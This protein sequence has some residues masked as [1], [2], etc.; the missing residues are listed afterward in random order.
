M[1]STKL[2]H[3]KKI[4][5]IALCLALTVAYVPAVSIPASA[6]DELSATIY[7]GE[8]VSLKDT[9][10][11]DYYEIGTAKELFAF[12]AIANSGNYS[13][14]AILTDDIDLNPG[15]IFNADGT[16]TFNGEAVTEG[17]V[18]WTSIGDKKNP[19][20]GTFDGAGKTISGLYFKGTQ[21]YMGL[22]GN[23]SGLIKNLNITNTYFNT[24]ITSNEYQYLGGVSGSATG[25][26]NNC[27][28]SGAILG[29]SG[30][31]FYAGG[32]VGYSKGQVYNCKNTGVVDISI[33]GSYSYA[34][35]IVGALYGY[36]TAIISGCENTGNISVYADESNGYAGGIVGFT[37]FDSNVEKCIN[38]GDVDGEADKYAYVGGVAGHIYGNLHTSYSFGNMSAK[39]GT[40][41]DYYK[42]A[43]AVVVGKANY[44]VVDNC[45]GVGTAVTLGGS[46]QYAAG[47]CA[48]Q[49]EAAS[50]LNNYY[51]SENIAIGVDFVAEPAEGEFYESQAEGKTP[52]QFASGEVA[53]LLGEPF[54]QNVDNGEEVQMYPVFDGAKVYYAE[55]FGYSNYPVP[56]Y[57]ADNFFEITNADELVWFSNYVNKINPSA[58]AIL[59]ADIDYENNEWKTILSTGLYY[60]TTEYSDLGYLGT[61]D[62]NG[63]IIKNF[64]LK[65]TSG[66]NCTVGLFGTLSGTV[67]N[68]GVEGV[69]FDLNGATD[70]RA[71]G[72]A[73]QMLDGSLIENCYVINSD[74]TPGSFIV[75]GVA[76]C[77]YAATI[78]NC[79]TK[80]VAISANERCGNLVSDCRGDISTTDRVGTVENC[81]TDAGRVTGTQSVS[82]NIINCYANASKELEN[83]KAAYNLGEA[84]GQNINNSEEKQDYPVLNGAKIYFNGY[85]A[86]PEYS[87]SEST[88]AHNFENG[89]CSVC[90]LYEISA[91]VTEENYEA[92]N[93]SSD[94]IGYYSVANLGQ[95]YWYYKNLANSSNVVLVSDMEICEDVNWEGFSNG[96]KIL[97]GAYHTITIKQDNSD[98]ANSGNF[99]FFREL[100]GGTV[101]NIV[102]KGYI[103]TNTSGSVGVVGGSMYESAIE[104]VTSYVSITNIG[105]G[106]VGGLSGYYGGRDPSVIRNCAV[107]ADITGNGNVGGLI[108]SGWGGTRYYRVYNSAVVGSVSGSNAGVLVGYSATGNSGGSYYPMQVRFENIYYNI[109][110][111]DTPLVAAW[112]T[113]SGT[114]CETMANFVSVEAKSSAQFASGEVAHLLQNANSTQVWGQMSNLTGSLPVITTNELYKVV[115]VGGTGNYSVANVGDTNGDGTVDEL[116]Y[117]ALVNEILSDSNEQI[118]TANYDDIVRYDLDGDGY[119]DVIDAAL[120]NNLINGFI[121]IDVYTVGDYDCNGKAF[122]EADITAIKLAIENPEVLSTSEKYASDINGDGKLSEED[123]TELLR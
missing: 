80:N 73:G 66:T 61:F 28:F 26:I 32:I 7:S 63:H 79:F 65:A 12:A 76:G 38:Y 57:N 19:Y 36:E 103:K 4:L 100:N 51:S 47:V 97:D 13:I 99:G 55:G 33:D 59:L 92:F 84:F 64:K 89:I 86:C 46:E 23:M 69:S 105:S 34:G 56:A 95:L 106:N 122:E 30:G 77:N 102:F 114:S 75:G 18:S 41:Y 119:L 98:T 10:G 53:Y 115:E 44:G 110:S 123:L 94:Y 6:A 29:D 81:W 17:Y 40:R 3:I 118:E 11:D 108:G 111:P 43:A 120:M 54:G 9:D 49:G 27:S 24:L 25:E 107:Y 72:I 78:R 1:K 87:N 96:I 48:Y 90:N 104:N 70:V 113:N 58:N 109:S 35:G 5:S 60:N 83:G 71:A 16:V 67:K 101:K 52:E 31:G 117:Q 8:T 15:Y 2:S 37:N 42:A 93:L 21:T 116:D 22:F 50:L 20:S 121:T 91:L 45:Y 62:G 88:I 82:E 112:A 74:L 39:T 85:N 68:L 14:N